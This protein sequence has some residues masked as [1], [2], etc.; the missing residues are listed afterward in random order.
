MPAPEQP[1]G[2]QA[3]SLA[4]T[5][6]AWSAIGVATF[7]VTTTLAAGFVAVQMA[8]RVITPPTDREQDIRIYSVGD[9]SITLSVTEESVTPGQ[10]SLFFSR[11]TGHARV[12]EIIDRTKNTVTRE[13]I[14]VDFGD[15]ESA[16]RG[17]FSGWFYVRPRDLDLAYENVEVDTQLGEAPAWLFPADREADA[18]RWVIGVHGR[19]VRRQETLRAVPVFHEQGYNALLISYRNDGVAPDSIDRRYALG[20]AEW[21]DVD[22]AMRYALDHGATEIV[23]LGFSMGGATVLQ[24]ATRSELAGVIRGIV[25]DSPVIDWVDV[26]DHQGAAAHV[27]ALVRRGAVALIGETW[28][29]PVTG[30]AEPIDFARLDFVRRARELHVPVLLLHSA[31]DD[32]VPFGPSEAMAEERPD[33]VTFEKFHTAG[34]VRLWNYDTPR[35][36]GAITRWL[37]ALREAERA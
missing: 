6:V 30:L 36:T 37:T 32:Y 14:G 27:P 19:G 22:A 21:R 10:Y 25:L 4:G 7:A 20:G 16:T 13:L 26:L 17:R 34:H 3:R 11:D 8:R 23:L 24:A 1:H 2:E 31:D 33:I 28:A 29:A 35:W 12:G 15:I 9:S 5:A 18:N